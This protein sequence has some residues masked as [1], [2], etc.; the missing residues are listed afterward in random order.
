MTQPKA[1]AFDV[2][3][4]LVD[5]IGIQAQLERHLPEA[6]PQVTQAWRQKQLEYTFRLAAM[7]RYEDFRQVT[8]KALDHAL[9][10][11]GEE[12][13]EG[14]KDD[15]MTR[16]DRLDRFEDAEPGL[17]R[18]RE[19]G[20]QMVAFSNGSPSMISAVLDNAALRPYLNN[21]ISVDEV[22]TYKP[23]P[24]VYRHA[25]ERLGRPVGE[26]RLI[27]SNPFDVIGAEAAGMQAAWVDRSGG[28]FD[29][30]GP[31]PKMV[32]ATLVELADILAA[33]RK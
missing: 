13:D 28:V 15:L 14:Q 23:S 21:F 10:V 3:G 18:L 12:L 30:L 7:E 24:K 25:A 26:V 6:A 9:A 31:R 27:S 22:K 19:A 33:Q 5:P 1:L 29:T 20:H 4:T 2:Y 32:V 17:R 16:Y 8:R 11:V